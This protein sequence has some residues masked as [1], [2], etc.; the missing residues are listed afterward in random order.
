MKVEEV[1]PGSCGSLVVTLFCRSLN[2]EVVNVISCT[3]YIAIEPPLISSFRET[4][5]NEK[6]ETDEEIKK[7]AEEKVRNNPAMW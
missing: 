1:T 4:N 5:K 3:Q 2:R 6:I 7:W